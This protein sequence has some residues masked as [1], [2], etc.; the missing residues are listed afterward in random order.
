MPLFN[1]THSLHPQAR[2]WKFD[3]HLKQ[4]TVG[5][6]VF[7]DIKSTPKFFIILNKDPQEEDLLLF[8]SQSDPQY[9][10]KHPILK[11]HLIKTNPDDSDEIFH[12]NCYI[13]CTKVHHLKRS[14]LLSEFINDMSILI[15]ILPAALLADVIQTVMYSNLIEQEYQEKI[16]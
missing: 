14:K 11:T 4:G 12:K 13:D 8:L 5:K 15:G 9:A 16:C 3:Q 6:R 7:Q 10:L 2:S 1:F